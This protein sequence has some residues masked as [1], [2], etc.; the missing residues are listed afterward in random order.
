MDG[1]KVQVGKHHITIEDDML[2]GA[3]S[4]PWTRDEMQQFFGLVEEVHKRAGLVFLMTVVLPGYGLTPGARKYIA[5][6][7]KDHPIVNGNV[8]VGADVTTRTIIRLAQ[9][10]AH[11]FG[12][13]QPNNVVTLV[14]TEE[15]G[16][17]WIARERQARRATARAS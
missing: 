15:Q 1:R 12:T 14:D 3:I 5:E 7:G 9:V 10:A 8:V 4:A 2:I 6:W 16:R 11:I 17:A 13:H